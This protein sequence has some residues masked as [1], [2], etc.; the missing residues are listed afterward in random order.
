M[1]RVSEPDVAIRVNRTEGD[2]PHTRRRSVWLL[3][4][5]TSTTC[6]LT[7]LFGACGGLAGV[8]VGAPRV[9]SL[10]R[11]ATDNAIVDYFLSLV[12][13]LLLILVYGV[14]GVLIGAA[15]GFLADSILFGTFL[16]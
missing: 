15:I 9:N 16:K 6:C 13:S 7:M 14:V 3:C 2:F 1:I 12:Y 5:A 4:G 10:P 11:S 8:I